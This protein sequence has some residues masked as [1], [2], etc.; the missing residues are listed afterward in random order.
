M[1]SQT[2]RAPTSDHRGSRKRWGEGVI[3]PKAHALPNPENPNHG[4][5][6]RLGR[7][8][9]GSGGDLPQKQQ[10]TASRPNPLELGVR[11]VAMST[12]SIPS[13]QAG[14]GG[15]ERGLSAPETAAHL[16]QA[17]PLGVGG[18]PRGHEHSVHASEGHFLTLGVPGHHSQVAVGVLLDLLGAEGGVHVDALSL[19][20]LLHMLAAL[21]VEACRVKVG[22]DRGQVGVGSSQVGAKAEGAGLGSESQAAWGLYWGQF[23]QIWGI[24]GC[25]E[26]I[27]RL[28]PGCITDRQSRDGGQA[29]LSWGAMQTSKNSSWCAAQIGRVKVGSG[30]GGGGDQT[31]SGGGRVACNANTQRLK[32]GCRTDRQGQGGVQWGR[33]G[34]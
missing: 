21:Q 17:Q 25:N 2:L 26:D 34:G 13:R 29:G 15:G 5:Q 33:R 32:L 12:V 6:G 7:R 4:P 22:S 20:L 11:P 30:R 27:Q 23:G 9:E 31:G 18:S 19:V 16:F 8:G 3:F 24:T 1:L 10:L 14:R 28:L